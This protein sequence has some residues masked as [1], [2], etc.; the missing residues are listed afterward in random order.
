MSP[1]ARA[2]A[3]FAVVFAVG[4]GALVQNGL[5]EKRALEDAL[6]V[7]VSERVATLVQGSEACQGPVEFDAE[8]FT[9]VFNTLMRPGPALEASYKLS[10]RGNPIRRVR[11]P[12][13]Y[14]DG[15]K[16][17]ELGRPPRDRLVH[18][19]VRNLETR[20]VEVYG[21][22]PV[23]RFDQSVLGAQAGRY[24]HDTSELRVDGRVVEGDAFLEFPA[25]RPFSLLS[26][27]PDA[28][29][30][31]AAWVPAPLGT[32][33]ILLLLTGVVG[34]G[35]AALGAAVRRAAADDEPGPPE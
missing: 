26:E 15:P 14:R 1:T 31:A 4:L 34:G 25:E 33:W 8:R 2:L 3:A 5:T 30:H 32:W 22:L 10:P 19:C 23:A 16:T 7:H 11:V 6:G 35:A 20:L 21:T 13:G 18:V 28:A 27:L 17:I 12:P 24:I 29:R 9:L